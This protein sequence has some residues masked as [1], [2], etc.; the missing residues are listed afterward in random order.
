MNGGVV[1]QMGSP[2]GIRAVAWLQQS[3]ELR[4]PVMVE[5]RV[6]RDI[7]AGTGYGQEID[8]GGEDWRRL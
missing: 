7:G 4:T 1:L 8:V 2:V 5:K 3:L 6:H